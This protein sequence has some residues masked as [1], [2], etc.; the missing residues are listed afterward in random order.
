MK[1]LVIEA[2]ICTTF[3]N[4]SNIPHSALQVYYKGIFNQEGGLQPLLLPI[5]INSFCNMYFNLQTS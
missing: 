5:T 4:D 3:K 1:V 2:E